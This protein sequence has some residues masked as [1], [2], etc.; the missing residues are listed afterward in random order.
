MENLGKVT[1]S[2]NLACKTEHLALLKIKMGSGF[3]GSGAS[4][5]SGLE[6][7]PLQLQREG[8]G[9][10]KEGFGWIRVDSGGFGRIRRD[11]V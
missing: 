5:G 10:F 6:I 4:G 9:E 8:F 1:R 7:P 3:R 11:S 2:R